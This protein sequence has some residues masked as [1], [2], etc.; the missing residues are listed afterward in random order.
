MIVITGLAKHAWNTQ[1]GGKSTM[2]DP[3]PSSFGGP[4]PAKYATTGNDGRRGT[5]D[6]K[7]RTSV[8]SIRPVAY[9]AF[10]DIGTL[11]IDDK[12]EEGMWEGSQ[13]R[14]IS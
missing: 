4:S 14:C 11:G 9:L 13:D 1:S 2:T 8:P 3:S 12:R 5:Q 10:T 7:C 6:G